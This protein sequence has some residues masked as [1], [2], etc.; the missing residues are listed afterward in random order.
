MVQAR[1]EEWNVAPS[2]CTRL[3]AGVDTMVDMLCNEMQD[4][5]RIDARLAAIRERTDQ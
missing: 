3:N 5:F 1:R 2:P 4:R